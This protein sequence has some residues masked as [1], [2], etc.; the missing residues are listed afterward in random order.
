MRNYLHVIV[1]LLSEL[2]ELKI[3][4][5]EENASVVEHRDNASFSQPFSSPQLPCL[6]CT[7]SIK[8]NN[9]PSYTAIPV[10]STKGNQ[11]PVLAS[12]FR[13]AFISA[14]YNGVF[15]V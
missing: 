3:Q 13:I 5:E 6:L 14:E 1:I 9:L 12:R 7:S 15:H 8:K 11:P 4:D 10:P 2:T